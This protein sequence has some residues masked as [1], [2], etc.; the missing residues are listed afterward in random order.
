MIITLTLNPSIDYLYTINHFQL[1]AQNRFEKPVRMVGGK[2]INAGRTASILGSKV[3]TTGVLGGINGEIVTR[4]LTKE[5]FLQ[6]FIEIDGETR[7]AIT[8]M[9]NNNIQTE[10]T[11][12]G[13]F[14]NSKIEKNILNKLIK[15]CNSNPNVK[16]I[17]L[18]GSV[19]SNNL[20]LYREFINELQTNLNDDVK[21]LAD[22]SR[23]Q[24]FEV[25]NSDIKPYFIKPNIHEFSE[26]VG[27][28]I[29]TKEEIIEQLNTSS[30][31]DDIPF[32]VV[33]CGE[34]GAIAKYNDVIYDLQ[35]PN[36]KLINPTGSG[37]STV[38]GIAYGL[39]NGLEIEEI[40]KYAMAAGVANAMEEA[41]GFISVE[42]VTKIK[43]Q[44]KI[45]VI[46]E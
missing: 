10:I 13:P 25:L 28:D 3:L 4:F 5:N 14:I 24:L 39:D 46:K 35:T 6:D 40:L 29:V 16:V 11:E 38:G 2:G 43:N 9:H 18:S 1:G 41:V 36:I 22:I 7:N 44:V 12:V 8:I 27:T 21:V 23:E 19:N 33:S 26:V 31:F 42:N 32:I 17:C 45:T 37:D 15:Q 30:L 20:K 34:K